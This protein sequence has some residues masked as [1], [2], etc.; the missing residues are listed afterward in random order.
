M[1]RRKR[2]EEHQNHEAWAIPYGDLVTLLLAFFVVMYAM[3]SVNEGK[4]RIL[5]DSL[6]AAFRGTPT[7]INPVQFGDTQ[8]GSGASIVAMLV[9]D[10]SLQEQPR[11]LLQTPVVRAIEEARRAAA[12]PAAGFGVIEHKSRRQ[13]QEVADSV[14]AAMAEMIERGMIAVRRKHDTVEVEIRADIL[15]PSGQSQLTPAAERVIDQLAGALSSFPNGIN[16]EGHTDDL[17][18]STAAFPSNWEL[19][20][21]RA[22]TV[23]HLL[24]QREIA[25]RRLQ[26]VGCGEQ[27]P[28]ATNAT[29][30]GRNANRRVLLVIRG[31]ETEVDSIVKLA[32]AR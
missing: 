22:A 13:L 7:S 29:V 18:I 28:V 2:H 1:A 19:S 5:S 12:S 23:V 16:V 24:T 9:R 10:S 8:P 32:D 30:A 21:A 27:Q 6:N 14:E 31:M 15:F 26:V 20:A 11:G 17:P 4:Y 25:P 3:S